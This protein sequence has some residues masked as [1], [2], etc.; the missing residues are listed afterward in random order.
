MTPAAVA[1][2]RLNAAWNKLQGDVCGRGLASAHGLLCGA[3][4]DERNAWR[5]WFL[6]PASAV[7]PASGFADWERK[8]QALRVRALA[9][10]IALTA[11]KRIATP[12]EEAKAAVK[13][14]F[15]FG[16]E[17]VALAFVAWLAWQWVK[18]DRHERR[19]HFAF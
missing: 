12:A 15:A 1:L 8:Y 7:A 5:A 11:P 10:G 3:I 17:V 18:D 13:R 9:E 4:V 14:G 16:Q 6:S 2:E 19:E